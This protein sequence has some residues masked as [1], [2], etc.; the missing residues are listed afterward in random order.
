MEQ[1]DFKKK[2]LWDHQSKVVAYQM[3]NQGYDDPVTAYQIISGEEEPSPKVV[4][5]QM[6]FEGLEN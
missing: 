4:L 1:K 3:Y 6:D 2:P 5:E